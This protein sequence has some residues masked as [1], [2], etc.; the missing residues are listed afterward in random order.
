M[1][2]LRRVKVHKFLNVVPGCEIELG[3]GI[4]VL[5]G[6][7]GTGKTTLLNWL[8]DMLAGRWDDWARESYEV[9]LELQSSDVQAVIRVK[10]TVPE[11]TPPAARQA[12]E[13]RGLRERLDRQPENAKR[14]V[15]ITIEAPEDRY[16]IQWRPPTL[17]LQQGQSVELHEGTP[18]GMLV[19]PTL[20]YE[21]PIAAQYP[22]TNQDSVLISVLGT[23]L[24]DLRV[25]SR[26]DESL[27]LFQAAL[28]K[29]SSIRLRQSK[30]ADD[31][32]WNYQSTP[33]VPPVFDS[34][35]T[36]QA[37]SSGGGDNL[38]LL[39]FSSQHLP[40]LERAVTL[41]GFRSAKIL[42]SILGVT[43]YARASDYQFGDLRVMF[44]CQD[45]GIIHHDHL[46]YGQKRMLAFLWYL[47][48]NRDIIIVDELVNG[49][50][51]AWIEQAI[52]QIGE[53]QAIVTSQN[54]L[55]LDYLGFESA[56]EMRRR[57]VLCRANLDPD[58]KRSHWEWR[59]PSTSEAE[60][61]YSAY[62]AG[63]QHVGEILMDKGLW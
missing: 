53:R 13:A 36:E 18:L 27:G 39:S 63:I 59:N 52:E 3:P 41:F 60:S 11:L 19:D 46:S 26:F 4:N 57:F 23:Q 24:F 7:N 21:Q 10:N 16:E 31:P 51:H 44:T 37:F 43:S 33:L 12:A 9:E 45:G 30:S 1:V 5:L 35:A 56:D 14:E 6:Q 15:D 34:M 17:T 61:F 48:L 50:H 38:S 58:T 2:V 55:L 28:G 8:S 22:Y 40:Y 54:P 49:L 25:L 20:A 47:E 32:P 62:Q 29:G 42:S